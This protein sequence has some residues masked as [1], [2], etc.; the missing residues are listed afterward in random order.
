MARKKKISF[1]LNPEWMFKEPL[2]F[3]YNK[4]TLLD[5][6]QKCE[7]NFDNLRIYPDFVELSLHIANV[8]SLMK[9]NVLLLTDKKFESCDDEILLKELYPKKPR[10]LKE[11]EKTELNKTI[12]YSNSKLIDAFNIAKSIWTIAYDSV[13]VS[14]KKNKE[15]VVVGSGFLVLYE[16]EEN[17]IIVWEY[18][19]KKTKD[20]NS[21]Y[22]THLRKIHEGLHHEETLN[23]VI[24]TKSTW[25]G[26]DFLKKLPVFEVKI[27]QKLP[28]EETIIPIMK[29]KTLT[30]I[31]QL[32]SAER[33]KKFD[34]KV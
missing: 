33:T 13:S 5:Y 29:R 20:K 4:Y 3:E 31:F 10:E 34:N 6:L 9:E 15:S 32:T 11:G 1:K 7:K 12:K 25:K 19:L 2:D 8:Q 27:T 22:K 23:I 16:K 28:L 17:K 21:D 14:L 26:V 30:L 18:E 24:E